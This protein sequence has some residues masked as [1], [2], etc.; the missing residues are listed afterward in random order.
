MTIGRNRHALS[1]SFMGLV[2]AGA[3]LLGSSGI[4]AW[5]TRR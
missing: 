4:H 2:L 1:L 3:L 5:A